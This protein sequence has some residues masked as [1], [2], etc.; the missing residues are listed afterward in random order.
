MF[1]PVPA[2]TSKT[3]SLRV[4][5]QQR[6]SQQIDTHKGFV[7]SQFVNRRY[8]QWLGNAPLDWGPECTYGEFRLALR[9]VSE[10]RVGHFVLMSDSCKPTRQFQHTQHHQTTGL[11]LL[12][13]ETVMTCCLIELSCVGW[14]FCWTNER[15][16]RQRL[17]T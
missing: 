9:D 4:K 7:L 11:D 13:E 10:F 2:P 16:M 14:V 12:F 6:S 8:L 17:T 5:V 15:G 3:E 1:R